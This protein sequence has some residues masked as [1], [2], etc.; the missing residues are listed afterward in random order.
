MKYK[1]IVWLVL[2]IAVFYVTGCQTWARAKGMPAK[3]NFAEKEYK[4]ETASIS[5]NYNIPSSGRP[6]F[7]LVTRTMPF[8]VVDLE[9]NELPKPAKNKRWEP[10]IVPAGKELNIR[11]IYLFPG[12]NSR[13]KLHN[14]NIRRGVFK[15]PPLEAG[16]KYRLWIESTDS[17]ANNMRGGCKLILTY[18]KVKKLRYG[19]KP[20]YEQ[21]YTQEIPPLDL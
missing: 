10:L 8:M 20:W 21:I 13:T 4:N 19:K 1:S 11:I 7:A 12:K 15:C 17:D 2:T 18:A 14:N 9:G 6:F 16:K 5:I 3:Y